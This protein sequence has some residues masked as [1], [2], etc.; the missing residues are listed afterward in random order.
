[1]KK[2]ILFLSIVL[3]SI[4]INAQEPD[5]N[6]PVIQ[7]NEDQ[8]D[9]NEAQRDAE[10]DDREAIDNAIGNLQ[11]Y[12]NWLEDRRNEWNTIQNFEPGACAPDFSASGGSMMPSTCAGNQ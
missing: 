12:M 5:Q 4:S 1:M 10:A 2:V 7:G 11:E 8:H 3:L 9:G 6:D